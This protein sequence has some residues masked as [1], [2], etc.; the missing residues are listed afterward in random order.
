MVGGLFG[1]MDWKE[2]ASKTSEGELSEIE[3]RDAARLLQFETEFPGSRVL[4]LDTRECRCA[5]FQSRHI[6]ADYNRVLSAEIREVLPED[7]L[8]E[9]VTFDYFWILDGGWLEADGLFRQTVPLL[10]HFLKSNGVIYVPLFLGTLRAMYCTKELWEP[11]YE[12]TLLDENDLGTIG[13]VEATSSIDS[14]SMM[15]VF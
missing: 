4:T 13:L 10:Y 15:N 9:S 2:I 7:Q 1:C 3:G 14:E 5:E 6:R 8:L 11:F 12:V